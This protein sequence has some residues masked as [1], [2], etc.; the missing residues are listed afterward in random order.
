MCALVG[1]V[2]CKVMLANASLLASSLDEQL[3]QLHSQA[4]P[5]GTSEI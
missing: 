2:V 3:G 1:L 5:L 4:S